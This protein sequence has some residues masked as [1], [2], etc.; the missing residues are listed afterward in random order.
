[1][2]GDNRNSS[3]IQE[4]KQAWPKLDIFE[5]FE[6]IVSLIVMLIILIIVFVA[7]VRLGK[8]VYEMLVVNALDP[9]EFSVFQRVFGNMLTLYIAMEFR[10]SIENV[11]HQR[12]HII[13]VRTILLIAILAVTRK[14]I[15]MDKAAS[16]ESMAALAFVLVALAG[17]YWVLKYDSKR[18]DHAS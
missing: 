12:G 1:M 16:P 9:L 18:V 13:Q 8:N 7:L 2:S 3:I 10:H 6:Y 14:F 11:L 17:V 15:V 5:R 4:V